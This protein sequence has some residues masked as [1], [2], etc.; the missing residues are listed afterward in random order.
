MSALQSSAAWLWVSPLPPI[1]HLL[2]KMHGFESHVCCLLMLMMSILQC[3]EAHAMLGC[4]RI[5][6]S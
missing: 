2:V 3:K 4:K 1:S 5:N 6:I